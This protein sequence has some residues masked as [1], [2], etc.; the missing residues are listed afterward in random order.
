[1]KIRPTLRVLRLR[2]VNLLALFEL[3][4]KLRNHFC[5]H[6]AELPFLTDAQLT[7]VTLA[8]VC[9]VAQA[10]NPVS[11]LAPPAFRSVPTLD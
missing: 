6:I 1:M 3:R 9:Q 10:G 4:H 8:L 11:A 7:D 2:T 5:Q